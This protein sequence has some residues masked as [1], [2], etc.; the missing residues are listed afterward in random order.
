MLTIIEN[1]PIH[2]FGVKASGQVNAE[3]LKKV[4]LLGLQSLAEK[5]SEIYY[6]L[7][8]ETKVENFTAGAWF[9]DMLAGIK[10]FSQCKKIAIVADQ[11]A[12]K[13][14]TDGFHYITAGKAKDLP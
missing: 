9:Q 6:M 1:L 11:K 2:V 4:L 10:H 5:Y 7:V 14:F 12:V 13:N 8:L 3:D